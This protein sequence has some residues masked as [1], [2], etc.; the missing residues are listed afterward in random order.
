MCMGGVHV[1]LYV[2]CLCGVCVYVREVLYTCGMYVYV[3]VMCLCV[4]G[5]WDV[6]CV[7]VY[8]GCGVCA[9]CVGVH[10]M[11]CVMRVYSHQCWLG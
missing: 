8:M 6:G 1:V 11:W 4:C 7:Y 5:M 3:C 2:M 9:R 10:G